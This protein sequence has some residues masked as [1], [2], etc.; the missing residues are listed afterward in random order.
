VVREVGRV[1]NELTQQ[2]HIAEALPADEELGAAL[3]SI[4]FAAMNVTR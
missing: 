1:L 4:Q 3:A 2:A